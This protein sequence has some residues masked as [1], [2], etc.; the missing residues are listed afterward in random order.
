MLPITVPVPEEYAAPFDAHPESDYDTHV[1]FTGPYMI[2]NDAQG[3]LTGLGDDITIVRNPNWDPVTDFRP[4]HV[5]KI[6]IAFDENLDRIVGRTLRGSHALC[7]DSSPSQ[8]VPGLS[9]KY[10]DQIARSPG[11][12]T[13]WVALNTTVGPLRNL[14]VRKAISAAMNRRALRAARGGP[15]AGRIARHF[16]P[17]GVPGFGRSHGYEGFA[18]ADFLNSPRG[19]LA[20]ARSYMLRARRDGSPVSRRGKYTGDKVLLMVGADSEPGRSVAIS[21]KRQVQRLGFHVRLR[22]V[23]PDRMYQRWCG[24]RSA[25]VAICPNVGWFFDFMDPQSLLEP[26]F[27]GKTVDDGNNWSFLDKRRINRAMN[28]AGRVPP[29]AARW[30]AWAAVNH[31]ITRKAPGVPYLWDTVYQFESADVNGVMNPYTSGWDLSF[32]SLSD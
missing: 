18:D 20:L 6:K 3:N 22:L 13:R 24:V 8:L 14:N 28:R 26:T 32:T 17:P 4:A 10:S 27:H 9:A 31:D 2:K 23:S 7:C 29:G 30:K 12:G 25:K 19:D 11:H 15:V 5:D 16:L 21:V 1:V